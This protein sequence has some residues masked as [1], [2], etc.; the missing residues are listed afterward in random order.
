MD[1]TAWALVTNKSVNDPKVERRIIDFE[2]YS[3][4]LGQKFKNNITG[5][6]KRFSFF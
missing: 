4:M 1:G 5:T 2:L 6:T 3:C